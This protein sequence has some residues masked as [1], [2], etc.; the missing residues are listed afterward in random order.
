MGRFLAR[1]STKR[2]PEHGAMLSDLPLID[3]CLDV[4]NK[5]S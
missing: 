3:N 5:L 4:V 2:L 1:S